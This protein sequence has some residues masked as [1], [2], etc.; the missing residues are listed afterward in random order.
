MTTKPLQ[1]KNTAPAVAFL[2][3]QIGS[4]TPREQVIR[5]LVENAKQACL[6][7][8]KIEPEMAGKLRIE[9][10]IDKYELDV[11]HRMCLRIADNGIGIE[12]GQFQEL[13]N[14]MLSSGQEQG[15][16]ANFGM[17][18]KVAGMYHN[19]LGMRYCSWT[20]KGSMAATLYRDEAGTYGMRE[21]PEGA[22]IV[23]VP[24]ELAD[25]TMCIFTTGGAPRGTCVTLLGAKIDDHTALGTKAGTAHIISYLRNRYFDL[26]DR[27]TIMVRMFRHTPRIMPY[28]EFIKAETSQYS[29][30]ESAYSYVVANS[31]ALGVL[32]L[33]AA[34]VFWSISPVGSAKR[35][36][37]TGNI[38]NAKHALVFQGE[39]YESR[40]SARAQAELKRYG[41]VAGF[42]R[43]RLFIQPTMPDVKSNPSRTALERIGGLEMPHAEWQRQFQERMPQEIRDLI[44][45][46][47]ER[48]EPRSKQDFERILNLDWFRTPKYK[49][50]TAGADH[51]AASAS[52]AALFPE[53]IGLDEPV[54]AVE[55][56]PR[57]K[58]VKDPLDGGR[59]AIKRGEG[60]DAPEVRWV[61]EDQSDLL[62]GH[63]GEYVPAA[64]GD[65]L[66]CNKDYRL[67]G[68][69]VSTMRD[70]FPQH[71][72]RQIVSAIREQYEITMVCL[73]VGWRKMKA[74]RAVTDEGI[75]AAM[76]EPQA[77]STAVL[78]SYLTHHNN[79]IAALRK[80]NPAMLQTA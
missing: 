49:P 73:V 55:P 31:D 8:L 63:A 71:D 42:N 29:R 30:C 78:A 34:R 50:D 76:I 36:G 51:V 67:F 27:V 66:Y 41:I 74:T 58:P 20:P 5:E 35:Q 45:R 2:V 59:P 21:N 65:V 18:A 54:P 75:L 80:A 25:E 37:G 57:K 46:E 11:N 52:G 64:S 62:R 32:E 69:L 6:N 56:Q 23:E 14:T 12:A 79:T 10:S 61:G 15:L 72:E 48:M 13:C 17:G 1:I 28:E 47:L 19:P 38:A 9:I 60:V 44:E 53:S 40:E 24:P 26:D 3:D 33:D 68:D 70:S 39:C 4:V 77:F 43:V 22:C 7:R 16:M